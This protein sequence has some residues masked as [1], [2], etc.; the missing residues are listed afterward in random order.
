MFNVSSRL[1]E[2]FASSVQINSL[3]IRRQQVKFTKTLNKLGTT[4][5]NQKLI[6][7]YKT[8]AATIEQ[9]NLLVNTDEL[10]QVFITPDN[11]IKT[12]QFI[13]LEMS[14]NTRGGI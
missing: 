4:A 8:I 7:S 3:E 9:G 6:G 14:E 10:S 1:L 5:Y 13:D 12:Y 2:L 11:L